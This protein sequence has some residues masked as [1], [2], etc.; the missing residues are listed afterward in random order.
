MSKPTFSQDEVSQT[1][2]LTE[3]FGS[4]VS[5]D[6]SAAIAQAFVDKIKERTA[7]GV[8]ANGKE[9]EP[10]SA[11][12]V[13][14]LSFKAA[15]KSAD[16]VNMELFGDMMGTL[17]V[18]ESSGSEIKIGW[19]DELQ[20]KKAFNHN[21]GDTLPERRFFGLKPNEIKE[22]ASQFIEDV[23][24][25]NIDNGD[26]ETEKALEFLRLLEGRNGE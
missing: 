22:I 14:S 10:Y 11:S 26:P 5:P 20:N 7:S 15:G 6:V 23:N 25:Q 17:D 2:D 24:P 16:E 1:I 21:T 18:L 8:D 12:Y 9:F 19:A 4:D 3:V 13:N